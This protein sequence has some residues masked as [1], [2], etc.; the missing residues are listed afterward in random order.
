M[1]AVTTQDDWGTLDVSPQT[2]EVFP[3]NQ[4][5]LLIDNVKLVSLPYS[6]LANSCARVYVCVCVSF[7]LFFILCIYSP[8]VAL[9]PACPP[10][11]PHP[12]LPPPIS[13]TMSPAT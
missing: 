7:Y 13:K 11:V 1:P 5:P 6:L 8:V 12:I 2:F 9:L 4:S 3:S 10:T